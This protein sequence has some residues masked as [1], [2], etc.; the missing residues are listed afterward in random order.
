MNKYTD[1]KNE[2]NDRG[3]F[4][5][6]G[7]T[8][9]TNQASLKEGGQNPVQVL[10]ATIKLTVTDKTQEEAKQKAEQDKAAAEK[11]EVDKTKLSTEDADKE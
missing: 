2:I 4:K 7:A 8:Q 6:G 10:N 11:N 5:V 9:F 1:L 3:Y